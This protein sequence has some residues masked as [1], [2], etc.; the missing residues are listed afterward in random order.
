MTR[1][2][3]LGST[4]LVEGC[5][6]EP[7]PGFEVVRLAGEP[8]DAALEAAAADAIVAFAPSPGERNL[9]ER[10]DLPAVIWWQDGAPVATPRPEQR[11]IVAAAAR[12]G[13]WRSAPLPVADGL[14]S[15]EE[16]AALHRAAWLGPPTP[17]RT[18][19]VSHFAGGA[20]PAEDDAAAGIAVNIH[21]DD[22]PACEHRALV[23]LAQGRLLVSETL[24]PSRGL[25]P[26]IDYL[27]ARDLD[28]VFLMVENAA[29]TPE[30]FRRVRLRGRRKAELFR[31]SRVVPRIV[32]DLLLELGRAPVAGSTP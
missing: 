26:G 20:R 21:D 29:R 32:G 31:A 24:A 18:G 28:D 30:A 13:V 6:P 27:E 8:S 14:Y 7:A 25:E 3:L 22:R 2:V 11:T 17:R 12:E 16:P 19:Y 9:I 5:A 10:C 23:A 4:A 15:D 1:A